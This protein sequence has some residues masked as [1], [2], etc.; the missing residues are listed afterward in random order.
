MIAYHRNS[1]A[2]AYLSAVFG[3]FLA[4][5]G[6]VA[7]IAAGMPWTWSLHHWDGHV[8][9]KTEHLH[10]SSMAAVRRQLD[11]FVD[12][13]YGFDVPATVMIVA[14]DAA[15]SQFATLLLVL[16]AAIRLDYLG[17]GRLTADDRFIGVPVSYA[18]P[19]LAPSILLRLPSRSPHFP[20]HT[21]VD[22]ICL[23]ALEPKYLRYL[24]KRSRA[25]RHGRHHCAWLSS[26]P[27]IAE[28]TG[29]LPA[30]RDHT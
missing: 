23:N 13:I 2:L 3:L 11:G 25:H 16:A 4:F 1:T 22:F 10:R 17:D 18:H 7:L 20:A 14:K 8:V 9:R 30:A 27:A 19:L 15:S 29:L 12:C 28:P 6:K 24:E 21:L 5:D 26:I